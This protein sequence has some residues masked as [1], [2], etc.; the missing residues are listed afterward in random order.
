MST[1]IV[2]TIDVPAFGRHRQLNDK[3]L[4]MQRR[5]KAIRLF[6]I[7]RLLSVGLQSQDYMSQQ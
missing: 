7:R 4:H 2:S 1:Q 5:S 3:T 6:P